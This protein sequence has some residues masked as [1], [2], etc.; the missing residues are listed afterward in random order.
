MQSRT[1]W[2]DN[3]PLHSEFCAKK[4]ECMIN[5]SNF[6]HQKRLAGCFEDFFCEFLFLEFFSIK[7]YSNI[8]VL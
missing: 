7:N 8:L 2:S 1:S 3:V 4:P 6:F 5:E